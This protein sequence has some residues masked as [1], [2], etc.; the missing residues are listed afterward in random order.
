MASFG[1]RC[2]VLPVLNTDKRT[3][4][5]RGLWANEGQLFDISTSLVVKYITLKV[6]SEF[7]K[8]A[9]VKGLWSVSWMCAQ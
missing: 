6:T 7:L 9:K 3:G 1:F 4:E 2:S 8:E 5:E